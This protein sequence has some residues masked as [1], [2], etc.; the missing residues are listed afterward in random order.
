MIIEAV[1][2]GDFSVSHTVCNHSRERRETVDGL[3]GLDRFLR[4]LQVSNNR[5]C[6]KLVKFRQM[7]CSR[8]ILYLQ[9]IILII[10]VYCS[11]CSFHMQSLQSEFK[12]KETHFSVF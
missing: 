4:L 8:S 3:L 7:L 6:K 11:C 5:A 12:E 1:P 9:Y 2:P 10:I